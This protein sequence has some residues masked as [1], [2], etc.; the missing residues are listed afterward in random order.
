M[1]I[2]KYNTLEILRETKVGLYLGDGK[3]E[4]LLPN[5]YV[6]LQ[7]EIGQE[8]DVFVYLDHEE[9]KVATTLEPYIYLNEFA[10]LRVNYTNEFGAFMDWGME[11]DL[12]VPFAEQ[13][14]KMEKGKRY[15]VYMFV[16]EKSNRLVGSSKTNQFLDN[17]E[18]SVEVGDEVDLLVSHITEA[19]INVIVNES[20]KGL[21]FENEV[22]DESIKPGDRLVGFIKKI[23]P[24]N[25]IDV[26]LEK[27]GYEKV[28]PNAQK[29]LDKLQSGRGFLRLNDESSP[30]DIKSILQMSK[31]TFKKAIG[32]LYKD[33]KIEIKDD[34]IQLIK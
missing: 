12:F 24:G 26:S 7:Y 11:K 30:E 21:L 32:A 17:S 4:V 20:F 1:K 5:K 16:D 10:L 9:R 15:I 18:L 23:R 34:G 2:G 29:I 22:F 27:Q 13:A 6:P 8:V 19:G 28:E 33:R 25:K 14:R 3:E 31:K